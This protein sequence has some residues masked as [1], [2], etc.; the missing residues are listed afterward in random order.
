MKKEALFI[1]LILISSLVS[2]EILYKNQEKEFY[3]HTI[4][5][6]NLNENSAVIV[7]DNEKA[8][9]SLEEKKKIG[10]LEIKLKEINY[11]N[12]EEQDNVEVEISPEP[13]CGDNACNND[14]TTNSCPKD[15]GCGSDEL[16]YDSELKKCIPK[17][18]DECEKDSDCDD[19]N[20]K[21][22]DLCYKKVGK[23]TV[24]KH[25]QGC[26]LQSDCDDDN[27]CTTDKCEDNTCFNIEIEG[28][29]NSEKENSED[30]DFSEE[31]NEEKIQEDNSEDNEISEEESKGFFS[32]IIS[33]FASWF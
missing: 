24:C 33:F 27:P 28:C 21:T 32:K 15:C 13:Y 9:I 8:P 19:N 10:D 2:A 26:E 4:M 20:P 11:Y 18:T 14:E 22:S 6:R 5:L 12:I 1:A 16:K 29:G 17:P 31:N 25:F 30:N 7:V 23:T 3:G